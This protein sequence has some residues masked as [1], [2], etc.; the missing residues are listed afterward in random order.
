MNVFV[1]DAGV[2]GHSRAA[3]FSPAYPPR[4]TAE[5]RER[6][7]AT[8]L[9]TAA[10]FW[11]IVTAAGQL[12]FASYI[13]GFYGRAT[14]AGRPE[15]WNKV[16]P[17][18]YVAGDTFFNLVLGVHLAFAFVITVAGLM[19]LVPAIRRRVPALHRWTG[20]AYLVAAAL[21]ATGGLTM[22]WVRGGAPGDFA[23]NVIISFNALLIFTCAAIAWRC[24]R[25]R[26]FDLHRR[27][28]LRLFL[29]VSGV[30]FFRIGL[31]FWIVVNRGPVGFDPDSFTGPALIV[32]GLLA[33]VLPQGVAGLYFR[34]Q[35]NPSASAKIA[36]ASGLT[37]LS[38]VMAVGIAA[39][40]AIMW[41]PRL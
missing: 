30:W 10:V 4:T 11:F 27:W 38:L 21:M 23:A 5:T 16:M 1:E 17:H 15:L 7:G 32:I 6:F 34:A 14:L 33:Y 20:R 19:Q 22:I 40:A 41:L 18:G 24:A 31:M 9:R 35:Q 39:A 13:A 37:V 29:A 2:R 36:T 3:A 25:A 12:I 8:A 28:A 26:R